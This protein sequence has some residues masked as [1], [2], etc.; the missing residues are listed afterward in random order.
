MSFPALQQQPSSEQEETISYSEYKKLLADYQL[1]KA[2]NLT[3]LERQQPSRK[4]VKETQT[5]SK[6]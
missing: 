6:F 3:L 2:L 5:P 1:I 4:E